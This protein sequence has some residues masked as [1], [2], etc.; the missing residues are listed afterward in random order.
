MKE[1]YD[2]QVSKF[3]SLIL[4][5]HPERIRLTL[6]ENGWAS[7]KELIVKAN[8]HNFALDL[9]ELKEVVENNDKQR[10][11]FSDDG[12]KIRANQGHS[13]KIDLQLEPSTPPA[14]LFHGTADKNTASIQAKGIIKGQRNH[15]HLS[16]DTKTA[17]KVGARYGKPI[18]LTIDA[19]AMSEEGC[20]FFESEN[21]VW[22]TEEVLPKYINW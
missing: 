3:L 2:V 5:H 21:G 18:I 19:K 20:I 1:N 8:D 10:F 17:H 13:V 11:I 4:R 9:E 6:D 22:L 15:V 16:T 12:T 14:V 7:V